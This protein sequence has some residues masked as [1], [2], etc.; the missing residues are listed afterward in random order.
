MKPGIK[1]KSNT[2]SLIVKSLVASLD[3]DFMLIIAKKMMD[4]YN[5]HERTGIEEKIFLQ[6]TAAAHQIVLDIIDKNLLPHFISF[7]VDIHHNE[8]MGRKQPIKNIARLIEEMKFYGYTFDKINKFFVEDPDVRITRNWGILLE[9]E[10]YI[11]AFIRFDIVGSAKL[12]KLYPSDLV[13][14]VYREIYNIIEKACLNRHGR[15]WSWEGD[16]GLVAFHFFKRNLLATLSAIEIINKLFIY[17]R[18]NSRLG[19]PV[20]LR[21]AVHTGPCEYSENEEDIKNSEIIKKILEIES[22][23]TK[24]NTVTIS[25]ITSINLDHA[26]VRHLA[27]LHMENSKKYLRYEMVLEN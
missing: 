5:I 7:L 21:L 12:V 22:L 8:Y 15:I 18:L 2:I 24:P 19:Q 20:E 6:K 1:I 14:S 9:G 26:L 3:I 10:E 13:Q 27:P 23:H 4:G 16:G 25:D 11:I 17:N